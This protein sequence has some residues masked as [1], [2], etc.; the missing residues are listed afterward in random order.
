MIDLLIALLILNSIFMTARI[1]AMTSY[2]FLRCLL[3][4]V[5]SSAP[6][7]LINIMGGVILIGKLLLEVAFMLGGSSSRE[8]AEEFAKKYGSGKG[9]GETGDR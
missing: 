9:G 5:V 2:S 6:F 3:I 4:G 8:I 1:K 7:L